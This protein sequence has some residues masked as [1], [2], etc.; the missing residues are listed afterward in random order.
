[1]TRS[2]GTV[3]PPMARA[4][5]T[6]GPTPRRYGPTDLEREAMSRLDPVHADFFA[7]AAGDES[8]LRANLAAFERVRLRPRVLRDVSKRDLTTHLLGHRLSMPV[9]VSP[10]A[11]HRLAHPDG[12]LATARAVAQAGTVLVVSMA[13]TTGLE[14]IAAAAGPQ[15][16]LWMQLY[17]QPDHEVTVGLVRR[18]EAAGYRALVVTVDSAV[19]GRRERDH[20]N[21]F[22]DLPTGMRCENLVDAA[23]RSRDIIMDPGLTWDDIDRLQELTRLPVLLKGVLHPQDARL[24][25]EHGVAGLMVSNHGGRQLDGVSATLDALPAIAAAVPGGY[26]LILDG[27]VRRGI[28][29]VRAL[30]LGATATGIGRPVLWGLTLGG[31]SGV[32]EVLQTLRTEIDEAMALCG[33][34]G[35]DGLDV[36]V[37]APRTGEER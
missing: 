34:R 15:A 18:A 14:Q 20:R 5:S 7:G 23:G 22:H 26:P 2:V 16:D 11:F 12:E 27:G 33:V 24:A 8:T 4:V 3:G 6:V 30:A 13:A 10:T 25:V 21:G 17:L 29:V 37:L 35:V 31:D 32:G 28:D 19:F 1:V 9:L 36:G